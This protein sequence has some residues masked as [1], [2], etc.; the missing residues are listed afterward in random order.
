[1][2][3]SRNPLDLLNL[4]DQPAHEYPHGPPT[5]WARPWASP[6]VTALTATGAGL[7]GFLLVVGLLAGRT[8]AEQQ[9]ARKDELIALINARQDHTDQLTEQLEE[10]RTRVAEAESEVTAALPSLAGRLR[11]VEE[12]A[13][14]TGIA[15]PGL[16]V[17]LTDGPADCSSQGEECR[18]QDSDLRAVVNA[19]F[20]AGA[21]AVAVNGER[22][23]STTAIRRA[24]RSVLVNYRVLTAPYTV[25]A[26]GNPDRLELDFARS[27]ISQQFDVWQD[28]YGLGFD[29]EL[30]DTLDVAGYAGSIRMRTAEV[31]G[32][33]GA[34]L[35]QDA[36]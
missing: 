29:V 3:D 36:P 18:I 5:R 6:L 34:G 11:D 9:D 19:L 1:M 35:P 13:G 17:V 26:V 10:L 32:D 21:E 28:V 25:E 24:G 30:A 16:R 15:G 31:V 8:S 27:D 2:N 20:G 23:I 12:A 7:V 22:L 14:L 4:G 33:L